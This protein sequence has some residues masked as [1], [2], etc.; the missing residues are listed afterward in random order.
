MTAGKQRM[1][2]AAV[3]TA[4]QLGRDKQLVTLCN[5][6]PCGESVRGAGRTGPSVQHPQIGS[7][8]TRTASCEA[9]CAALAQ[10]LT[11]SPGVVGEFC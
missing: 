2:N 1:N 4:K 5:T 9:L 3:L 7:N 10:L 11:R 6:A 8:A